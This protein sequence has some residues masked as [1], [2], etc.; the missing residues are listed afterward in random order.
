MITFIT[1]LQY[2]EPDILIAV[3]H[4]PLIILSET[5]KE[6]DRLMPPESGWS[7]TLLCEY[8]EHNPEQSG[9]AYLGETWV[10]SSE[11]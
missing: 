9:E 11:V 6:I 4:E 3:Q 7:H 10:G 8:A 2:E 5:G 1:D